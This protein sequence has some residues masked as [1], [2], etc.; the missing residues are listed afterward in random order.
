MRVQNVR[1]LVYWLL[2]ETPNWSRA[3]ID[4]VIRSAERKDAR[5]AKPVPLYWV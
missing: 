3:E 5:V 4:E 1:E 2:A